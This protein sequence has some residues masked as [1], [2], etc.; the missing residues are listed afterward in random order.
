MNEGRAAST[1][2]SSQQAAYVGT[3]DDEEADVE[4]VKRYSA[5]PDA[6]EEVDEN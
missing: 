4:V 5:E 3:E 1:G 6:D 2:R